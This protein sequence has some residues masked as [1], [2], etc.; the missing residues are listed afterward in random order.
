VVTA[1]ALF[2]VVTAGSGGDEG[3]AT[4]SGGTRPVATTPAAK[5]PAATKKKST[6]KS[7]TVKAGDTP[8]SIAEGAGIPLDQLLELNPDI[9][10][11]ALSPGQKLKLGP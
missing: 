8:S 10:P 11:Q 3:T 9:D 4:E 2:T 7:Y 1:V 5:K 6:A